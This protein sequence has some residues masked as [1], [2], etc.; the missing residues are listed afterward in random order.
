MKR[1]ILSLFAVAAIFVLG[2]AVMACGS[3]DDSATP[4][5]TAAATGT[6][7]AAGTTASATLLAL[8]N[9]RRR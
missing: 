5:A 9:R 7:A 6:A 1:R 4:T 8:P 2:L 3:D